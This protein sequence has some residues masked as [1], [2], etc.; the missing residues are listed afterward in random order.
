M[1]QPLQAMEPFTVHLAEPA[2]H[3]SLIG[4][5][6]YLLQ[7]PGE[8]TLEAQRR[9]WA[10]SQTLLARPEVESVVPG[11]TNLLVLFRQIPPEPAPVIEQLQHL[12]RTADPLHRAGRTHEIAVHYGGE[13]AIDLPALCNYAGLSDHEVVRRHHQARYSV[14]AVASAP[15]FGYLG[16]LDPALYMP[17]KQVPSLHMLKGMVT[18][19]GMQSGVAVLD[20][21]NGWNAIG[22]AD[23]VMFDASAAQPALLA[24]GDTVCFLPERIEL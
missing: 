2:A 8:L 4:A 6:A 15:G 20:G 10:L 3:V 13:H 17:R 7:A 9:I 19:G 21:P 22:F 1:N 5:R 11:M 12:W 16:G 23:A 14:F 18:I 24:P